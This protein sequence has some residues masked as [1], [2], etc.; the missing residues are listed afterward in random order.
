MSYFVRLETS[1]G[2]R[3][4]WGVDLRR[5]LKDSLTRPKIGDEIG[6][7]A[8]RRDAVKVFRPEHDVDGRMIGEKT[9]EAHR[10]AW[11]VEKRDFFKER[12]QA[13]RVLRD[14]SVDRQQAVKQHPELLGTYL[15]LHAAELAA[16]TLRNPEDQRRFVASVR[17]ALADSVARGEP[18]S[19]VPMKEQTTQ[20]REPRSPSVR[21]R[22]AAPTR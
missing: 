4:I 17:T 14:S 1:E 5:A 19:P 6:V 8:L 20:R 16:K 13:A 7:R 3:D 21:E 22:D 15:Q 11:I 9:L 2:E 12:G 10:N 18:L